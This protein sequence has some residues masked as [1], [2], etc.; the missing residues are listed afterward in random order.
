MFSLCGRY[1]DEIELYTLHS[2]I[3]NFATYYTDY[4]D[5]I[6]LNKHKINNILLK[7]E[8]MKKSGVLPKQKP[9]PILKPTRKPRK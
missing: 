6:N 9:K 1:L 5:K 2:S 7:L 3:S 8:N 4:T